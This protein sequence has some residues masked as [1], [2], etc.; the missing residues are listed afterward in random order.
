[1][2]E[3]AYPVQLRRFPALDPARVVTDGVLASIGGTDAYL[4][5]QVSPAS[6]LP[7]VVTAMNHRPG[8]AGAADHVGDDHAIIAFQVRAAAEMRAAG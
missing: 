4:E 5:S 2:V 8:A 7:D 3:R 6:R 1:M